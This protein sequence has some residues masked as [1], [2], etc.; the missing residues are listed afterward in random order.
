[1]RSFFFSESI[2]LVVFGTA[3]LL[4]T[5]FGKLKLPKWEK[6]VVIVFLALSLGAL[7]ICLLPV[8]QAMAG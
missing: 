2:T 7:V 1:M 3:L 4:W 6:A 8:K 5:L